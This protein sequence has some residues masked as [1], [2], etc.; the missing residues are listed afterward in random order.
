MQAWKRWAPI[1]GHS[2]ETPRDE[3]RKIAQADGLHI[4]PFPEGVVTYGAPK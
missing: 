4:S 3:L 2:P 1:L